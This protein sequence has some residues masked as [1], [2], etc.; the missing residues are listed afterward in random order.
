[1][2][3]IEEHRQDPEEQLTEAE[4]QKSQFANPPEF[5]EGP[6]NGFY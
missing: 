2:L 6:Q 3:L 1:M 5:P 4:K